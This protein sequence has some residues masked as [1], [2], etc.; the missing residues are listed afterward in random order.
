MNKR[1]YFLCSIALS[2]F[3]LFS[4]IAGA[5]DISGAGSTF[6]AVGY[7]KWAETY[8]QHANFGL[9]YQPIGSGAGIKQ[10]VGKYVDF[11]A[12]DVPMKPEDLS[13]KGLIQFPTL[14][15]GVVPVVNL[16]GIAPGQLKLSGEILADIYLGKITKWNDRKLA[17]ENKGINLPDQ[18]I[19][20]VYRSDESG[21]AYIFTSYLSQVSAAWQKDVG[22]GKKVK[23]PLGVGGRGNDGVAAYVRRLQGSIGFVEYSTVVKN[24]MTYVQLKNLDGQFVSPSLE[25]LKAAA[26]Y[27]AWDVN[28][29]F[30]QVIINQPGKESWPIAAA[31]FVLLYKVQ[32]DAERGRSVLGFFD[33][34]FSDGGRVASDQGYVPLPE[35]VVKLIRGAWKEQIKDP[36]GHNIL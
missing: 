6:A 7:E 32:T 14:I 24:K 35:N 11:G 20:V 29:G 2:L 19:Y 25:S 1:P 26:V 21:T 4:G 16:D 10:I 34:A 22:V 27:A 30:N 28:T 3:I 5:V 33:W 8:K 18:D 17:A 15:G 13:A 9:N 23:W 36:A 12:S 31:T